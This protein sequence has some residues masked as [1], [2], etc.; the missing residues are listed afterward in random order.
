MASTKILKAWCSVRISLILREMSH[1]KQRGFRVEKMLHKSETVTYIY[2]HQHKTA[3]KL[4]SII[5]HK[6]VHVWDS[7]EIECRANLCQAAPRPGQLPPFWRDAWIKNSES[8]SLKANILFHFQLHKNCAFSLSISF[9]GQPC[10]QVKSWLLEPGP[11]MTLES[12]V[13]LFFLSTRLLHIFY[14]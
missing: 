8:A 7:E 3:P 12:N 13:F 2:F 14:Y 5:H 11:Y 9:Y 10:R 6:M 1:F 4:C